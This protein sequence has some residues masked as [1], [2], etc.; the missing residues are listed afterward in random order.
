[1]VVSMDSMMAEQMVA[2]R[3]VKMVEKLDYL[4]A[5]LKAV[6]MV[7]SMVGSKAEK[8]VEPWVVPRVATRGVLTVASMGYS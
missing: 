2:S 6:S 7:G 4:K 3:G 1:M 8:M 5:E